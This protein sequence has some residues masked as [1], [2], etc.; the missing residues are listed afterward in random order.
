[1]GLAF[2]GYHNISLRIQLNSFLVQIDNPLSGCHQFYIGVF[3]NPFLKGTYLGFILYTICSHSVFCVVE[4]KFFAIAN[5]PSN[6]S[7]GSCCLIPKDYFLQN[8]L[9][10]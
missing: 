2:L 9:L 8:T 4:D 3:Q 6:P 7:T 5:Q 1:M 10:P